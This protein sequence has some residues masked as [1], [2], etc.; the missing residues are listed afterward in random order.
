MN[1]FSITLDDN[2]DVKRYFEELWAS[3]AVDPD[4]FSA[5]MWNERAD[6]W[7]SEI[8]NDNRPAIIRRAEYA[9]ALLERLGHLTSETNVADVGCGPGNFVL[10][11]ARKAKNALGID[12]ASKF[13]EYCRKKADDLGINNA[14]FAEHDFFKIDIKKAGYYEAFDLVFASI[15]PA[16]TGKGCLEKLMDMS[17]GALCICSFAGVEQNVEGDYPQASGMGFYSLFNILWHMG[18]YPETSYWSDG[19]FRFGFTVWDKRDKRKTT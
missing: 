5:E 15:P 19:R 13:L 17:K 18:F 2:N 7:I 9:C 3:R 4:E 12:Y 16:A 11:F 6:E 1:Q 10:E 14:S 8:E